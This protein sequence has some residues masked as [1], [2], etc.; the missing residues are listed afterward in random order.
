L[1]SFLKF[2]ARYEK[3]V[4]AKALEGTKT[5]R[6]NHIH[7]LE[8]YRTKLGTV[9]DQTTNVRMKRVFESDMDTCNTL[10]KALTSAIRDCRDL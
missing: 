9:R 8:S 10:I 4:C 6:G 1:E 7:L 2:N 5:V 3:H